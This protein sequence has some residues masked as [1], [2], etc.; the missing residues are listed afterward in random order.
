MRKYKTVIQETEELDG[1]FCDCCGNSLR[2]KPSANYCGIHFAV[3]GNYS[4]KYFTD[5]PDADVNVDVC[6]KCAAEWFE[7]FK[8]NPLDHSKDE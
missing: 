3:S 1:I 7:K 8:N 4:S 2:D 5:Y 6:E